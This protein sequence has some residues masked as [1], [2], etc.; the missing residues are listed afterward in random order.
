MS[1]HE[2]QPRDGPLMIAAAGRQAA[3]ARDWR[4]VNACGLEIRRQAP[5]D[6][7]GPFLLGLASKNA[8]HYHQA[9][10][11]FREVISLVSSRYDA[12][13]ELAFQYVLLN[14]IGDAKALLDQYRDNLDNSP[15]YLNLAGE[16]YSR[17]NL[18]ADALPLFERACQLQ[19]EVEM[20]NVNLANCAVS[21]GQ[22][23]TAKSIYKDLLRRNP[24]HRRNH[25]ELANL[26][27]AKNDRHIKKMLKLLP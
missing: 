19:P 25:Y 21:V 9:A 22:I 17:L 12:A 1:D 14:R 20:F 11:N 24:S 4:R 6:P 3:A 13:I 15:I 16:S 26:E 2:P 18:H 10:E 23:D 8:G 7:E 5:K 27:R